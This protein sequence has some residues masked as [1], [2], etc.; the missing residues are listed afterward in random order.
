MSADAEALDRLFADDYI[1][2]DAVGKPRTKAEILANFRTSAIR[3]PKIV[4]TSRTV[5]VLGDWAIVHGSEADEVECG[6][7]RRSVK[8]LYMD[9]VRKRE[10]RWQIVASQLAEP[11]G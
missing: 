1:Q 10:G 3:Y 7:E 8:Y 4:S 2:Y 9:V 6:G 11:A 5:R